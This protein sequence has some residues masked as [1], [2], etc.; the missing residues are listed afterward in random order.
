MASKMTKIQLGAVT[1]YLGFESLCNDL[2]VRCGYL[3]I[4]PLG[5][6]HDKGRDAIH[7]SKGKGIITIF[8]YSVRED[9]SKKLQEDLEKIKLNKHACNNVVFVTTAEPTTGQK[10]SWKEI[11]RSKYGWELEFYDLERIG[12]L[13]DGQCSDLKELHPNI[14]VLQIGK[15]STADPSKNWIHVLGVVQRLPIKSKQDEGPDAV[16]KFVRLMTGMNMRFILQATA[17]TF[18]K[19]AGIETTILFSCNV[20]GEEMITEFRTHRSALLQ[21]IQ[22]FNEIYRDDEKAYWETWEDFKSKWPNTRESALPV[23]ATAFPVGITYNR[24]A[25]LV[26]LRLD[27]VDR[28]LNIPKTTDDFLAIIGTLSYLDM[29]GIAFLKELGPTGHPF[30]KLIVDVMDN[31]SIDLDRLRVNADNIDEF[32]YI[33][34]EYDREIRQVGA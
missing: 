20:Q 24:D 9:W 19:L 16:T 12:T 27:L 3:D 28:P 21:N 15:I 5:G 1:D 23:K 33:N 13:L 25:R 10:D 31:Q 30:N 29:Q 7:F 6:Y 17:K 2:M 4:E 8:S 32:D 11:V 26:G 14:F 34:E 18:E 22:Y